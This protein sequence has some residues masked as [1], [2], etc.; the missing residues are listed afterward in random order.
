MN[1]NEIPVVKVIT[2]PV[3]EYEK[4]NLDF[5]EG[6]VYKVWNGIEIK[7]DIFCPA[8]SKKQHPAVIWVHG[9]GWSDENLTRKYLPSEELAQL[10]EKGY[11]VAS[12]DYRLSGTAP[13]PAQAEDCK[14][15]IRFLRK[16]A[17]KY[18]IDPERIA[19]WGESAGG[20]LA[21]LMAYS[22][23]T[24][25]HDG[26]YSGYS[27]KVQ[28]VIPW[29]APNDL[30]KSQDNI[31]GHGEDEIFQKLFAYTDSE[32]CAHMRAMAS[33]ILYAS[34]QNPPTL[35]MHGDAD[36][37]VNY[38]CS[39]QM[40]RALKCAGNQVELITV[41]EQGHGFFE[42][43]EYYQKIFTFLKAILQE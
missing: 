22:D 6:V 43:K 37:L 16:N 38:E 24:E 2:P 5:Y 8:N 29:Y 10:G 18:C 1:L 27:S 40:Y 7:M 31:K 42:G 34:R 3:I 28:A 13:F 26:N 21:E 15:A 36:K 33:P 39:I 17:S 14:T 20:H 32:V 19:V 12:I 30:R 4:R 35:L 9:G 11:V 41:P 23:D 25:F